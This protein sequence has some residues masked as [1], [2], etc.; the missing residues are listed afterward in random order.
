MNRRLILLNLVLLALAG[1]LGWTLRQRWLEARAHERA[2]FERAAQKKALLP[3][4]PLQTVAPVSAVQYLGVAQQML[5]SKDRNP[6]VPI[7]APPP[8]PPEPPMPPLPSYYG[9]IAIADPVVFLSLG[10]AAQ[11][12]YRKGDKV[13][14]FELLAFDREKITLGWNGKTV[15]RR[16]EELRPKESQQQQN[17]SN[18]PP[19]AAAQSPAPSGVRSLGGSASPGNDAPDS[20]I[21]VDMGAGN[22]ACVMGDT[23]PDGTVVN[24]Y[25]KIV[26]QTLMGRSCHWEQVK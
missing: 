6:N 8:P 20:K 22:R 21:G 23:T 24:G 25:K 3:P 1:L 10:N 7:E 17:A 16:L 5:F 26:S 13:G 15:D 18:T 12:S 14:P 4:P 11:K 9:Q 19:P 2:I